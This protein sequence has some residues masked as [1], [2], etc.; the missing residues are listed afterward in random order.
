[1][2]MDER[3]VLV[4]LNGIADAFLVHD[5]PI[6]RP[7]DDSVVL[8]VDG[9]PKGGDGGEAGKPKPDV[10][11]LRRARGYV[12]QAIGLGDGLTQDMQG[13]ILAVG[14]HLKNVVAI[15]TDNRFAKLLFNLLIGLPHPFQKFFLHF[16][17]LVS[18]DLL[19]LARFRK[20]G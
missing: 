4:R 12:P 20:L 18:H 9:G 1:M 13:P 14:G 11:I 2:V 15:L 16:K 17:S 7:V 3:E 8:V 19:D 5:R 6:A 10:M